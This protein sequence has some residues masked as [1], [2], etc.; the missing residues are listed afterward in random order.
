M[1]EMTFCSD[2][3]HIPLTL[4]LIDGLW[5]DPVAAQIQVWLQNNSFKVEKDGSYL[6]VP[7]YWS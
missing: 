7:Y 3:Y 1:A 4:T 6:A 2:L 5:R